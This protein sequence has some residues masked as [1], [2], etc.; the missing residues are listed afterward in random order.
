MS[1]NNEHIKQY[2]EYYLKLDNPEFA[3]LLSGKWGSGKTYFID[4]FIENSDKNEIKFI[5]ISLFGLK[6]L[7]SIDIEIFQHLHPILGHRYS[8]LA[9]N[10]VKGA[11]KVGFKVDFDNDNK[12]DGTINTDLSKVNP[13]DFLSDKSKVKMV[14]I[15]DD[16]E[17]SDIPLVDILGY[18]NTLVEQS[19]ANV[20]VLAN[21]EQINDDKYQEF[22]EKVVGKTFEVQ[23]DEFQI[24]LKNFIEK[25]TDKSTKY[26][27]DNRNKIEFVYEKA[28][29]KNLRHIKQ[30]LMD[31]EFFI[32]KI[33]DRY[34][35]NKRFVPQ[36]INN[37]FALSI[38]LKN[39]S[40]SKEQ[41]DIDDMEDLV[42][43]EEDSSNLKSIFFKYHIVKEI[44]FNTKEW[45]KIL[46]EDSLSKDDIDTLLSQIQYFEKEVS[47][48]VKLWNYRELENE[49]FEK[50]L[51][52]VEKEFN[53]CNYERA[54]YF[55]HIVALWIFLANEKLIDKSIVDIKDKVDKCLEVYKSSLIWEHKPLREIIF[56]K[57]GFAYMNYEDEDFKEIF[58]KVQEVTVEVYK[59]NQKVIEDKEL[60]RLYLSL[61]TFDDELIVKFFITNKR[62]PIFKYY[63]SEEF[64]NHLYK[65]SNKSLKLFGELLYERYVTISISPNP[66]KD[67]FN[68]WEEVQSDFSIPDTDKLHRYL[69]EMF[70]TACIDK[71]VESFQS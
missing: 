56:N 58:T 63:S 46:L 26:L 40:L 67:E 55:L 6:S 14:F 11:I 44:I 66:L 37:F 2:L 8:R 15:F 70:K 69:L 13:L 23:Q 1:K 3:V 17:R 41:L 20:I 65:L 18:I 64:L 5:K 25:K 10:V 45:S 62:K 52:D 50:L 28:G 35:S 48:W 60:E 32:Q 71:I 30:I 51:N 59:A 38:E 47:L 21:E 43:P 24:I 4:N 54:E 53:E 49:E 27:L 19:N 33:D 22:K 12:A 16:L 7:D 42:T 36:L 9:G 68:F 31:F 34:L 29:Y 61:D 39:N 57:T